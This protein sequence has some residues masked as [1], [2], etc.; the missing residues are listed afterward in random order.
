MTSFLGALINGGGSAVVTPDL[1]KDTSKPITNTDYFDIVITDLK[2]DTSYN[3]QFAWVYPDDSRSDYSA[4]YTFSTDPETAPDIP[5][6][7]TVTAGPGLINVTWNGNKSTGG[8]LQNYA[9]VNIYVDSVLKDF[10]LAAGTKSIPLAKGTYAVTLRSASSTNVISNATSPAVSVTVTT[11]A[12]DAAAALAGLD[13]KLNSAASGI[14]QSNNNLTAINSN[15]IT[16]YSSATSSPTVPGSNSQTNRLIMNSAGLVGYTYDGTNDYVSFAIVN[17]S[18]S[19]GSGSNAVSIP[20][21]SA[22]FRGEIQSSSG[23]I[24]GWAISASKLSTD[25]IEL[26]SDPSILGYGAIKFMSGFKEY[27]IFSSV[28]LFGIQDMDNNDTIL[29]TDLNGQVVVGSTSYLPKAGQSQNPTDFGLRNVKASTS[30]PI[31]AVDG[32][33]GDVWLKYTNVI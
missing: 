32:F 6:Q 28:G 29:S 12:T 27:A 5:S 8:A 16:V 15:G 11:D 20:A 18:F 1:L 19:Y 2:P 31:D 33:D 30:D 25:N 24:G 10:F 14:V 4:T 17:N 13:T 21:G 7:P 3:V 22:Y 9:K 26:I 23:K